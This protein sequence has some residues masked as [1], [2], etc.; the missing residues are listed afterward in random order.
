MD[1]HVYAWQPNGRPVPGWPVLVVDPHELASVNPVTNKVTFKPGSGVGQGTPL[2]DTPAI[3]A[4]N[5]SGPPDVVVGA[6]EEYSGE[7]S[8]SAAS[9]DSFV[10]GNSGLLPSGN[11]R[12]YA[13]APTGTRTGGGSPFLRGWPVAIADF[14][15]G[16]LP[17]RGAA[18]PAVA[19]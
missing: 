12:V 1:R 17:G 7:P 8:V 9:L 2:I 11:S 5:G 15:I 13:I 4:L 6:D 10:L 3:G 19:Q 16:L 14:D 18:R